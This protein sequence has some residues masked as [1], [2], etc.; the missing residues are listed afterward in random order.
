MEEILNGLKAYILETAEYYTEQADETTPM[1]ALSENDIIIGQVDLTKQKSKI[2]CS[3]IPDTQEP[4]D[5]YIE[6]TSATNNITVTFICRGAKIDVLIRQM[7]RYA[8]AFKN[9]CFA[10][11]SCGGICDDITIESVK[12]YLDAGI[13]DNQAT[14]VEITIGINKS[15]GD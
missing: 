10:D 6:G 7:M 3:L 15:I 11:N 2:L 4:E 12:Y 5:A 14:A 9:S 8:E 13:I 1:Y